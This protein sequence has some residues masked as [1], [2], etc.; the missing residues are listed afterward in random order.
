MAELK[1]LKQDSKTIEEFIQEFRRVAKS[2]RYKERL[3][4]KKFKRVMNGAIRR[5]LMKAEYQPSSI[6][7]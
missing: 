3:L 5:K 4:I 6:E 1:R 7:Q 2:S